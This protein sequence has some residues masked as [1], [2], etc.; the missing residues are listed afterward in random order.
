ML[1]GAWTGGPNGHLARESRQ[2]KH[3]AVDE[4]TGIYR[5][6]VFV[7]MGAL[8]ETVANTRDISDLLTEDDEEEEEEER[9]T[10]P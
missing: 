3:V 2:R 1:T 4:E 6:E 9:G 10:D 7:I 5:G 8:S